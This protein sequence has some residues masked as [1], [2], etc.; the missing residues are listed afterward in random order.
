[1]HLYDFLRPYIR[2]DISEKGSLDTFYIWSRGRGEHM[3]VTCLSYRGMCSDHVWLLPTNVRFL[4]YIRS[5]AF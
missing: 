3:P 5:S 2:G 1:M 4:D